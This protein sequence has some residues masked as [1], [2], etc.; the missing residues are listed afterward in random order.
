MSRAET[1]K[2]AREEKC[3]LHRINSG[4]MRWRGASGGGGG[5]GLSRGNY[6]QQMGRYE[7]LGS[8]F[9]ECNRRKEEK[10]QFA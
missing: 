2:S 6:V 8:N 5:L 10:C 9:E 4:V 1:L 3:K 7:R